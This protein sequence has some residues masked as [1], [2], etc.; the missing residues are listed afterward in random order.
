MTDC[1]GHVQGTG[2]EIMEQMISQFLTVCV[3]LHLSL[4]SVLLSS[5]PE[6][7]GCTGLYEI[8]FC[9]SLEPWEFVQQFSAKFAAG[10]KS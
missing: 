7:S 9:Y 6:A 5:W 4:F 1:N 8:D 2:Q 3:T 10:N